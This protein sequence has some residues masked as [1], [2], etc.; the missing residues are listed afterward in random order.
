MI[1]V[2]M[3]LR[4]WALGTTP[5][6]LY[7]DEAFNGLDA[8]GVLEGERPIFFE[9][10]NGR[11]PLFIYLVALS[12]AALGRSPGAIRIVAALLGTLTIPA[13]YLMAKAMFD[14]RIGLLA[15]A[16]TGLTLW[17]V[18]LS[19]IGFRTVAMP[20]L[21]ALALW[22]LWL[23]L[24]SGNRRHFLAGGVAYG[25]T[26]Y[27]YLAARFTIL[28]LAAFGLYLVGNWRL[29]VGGWKM[30]VG[31]WKLE[32]GGW[33]RG[34]LAFVLAAL[35]VLVPLMTY[36]ATH[37]D[38]FLGRVGQVSIFS[39]AINDGDF[40]GTLLRHMGKT[41][42]MFTN[43]G[44]F[45][46]RHNVPL[47]PVFDPVLSVFFLL[48]L[49]LCF[50]RF[51]QRAEHALV[52]IWLAVMILPTILA[53]D[54]PHF[55]RSVGVLPVAFV[56]P[57]IGLDY[58]WRFLENRITFKVQS[59]K[60]KAQTVAVGAVAL[61][62]VFGLGD[63]TI[64][65]FGR[66]AGSQ[67]LSY[68]FEAAAVRLAT[69][70]NRFLST[71]WDGTGLGDRGNPPSPGRH[72]YIAD[73]LWRDWASVRFLVPP[74]PNLTI[75]A[76]SDK[77]PQISSDLGSS[78]GVLSSSKGRT[79]T[80]VML[81][82]WPYEDYGQYLSLLPVGSTIAAQ[83]GSLE[84]GDLEK[85]ARLLYITYTATPAT[86]PS[87]ELE[88]RFEKGL[89]LV[90][91]RLTAISP[92]EL[93]L[94]LL[95]RAEAEIEADYT[96]F[97]HLI[98]DGFDT[99]SA[100]LRQAQDTAQPKDA[101]LSQDD[102]PPAGGYYPTSLWRVGDIVSDE[103]T[104]ALPEPYDPGEHKLIVGFYQLETLYRLQVLD[105]TGKPVNDHLILGGT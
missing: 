71:G 21:V 35:V 78:S 58:L 36:V 85:E 62:L 59:S 53:E 87:G 95:W 34:A 16:V 102:S 12:V 63:T 98:R 3:A 67:D 17:H 77:L 25:L 68:N 42:L 47:R 82:L 61:A 38:A 52:L 5:P 43:R 31:R 45:I 72:L 104:L 66:H 80:E 100:T 91:H 32:D 83:E 6:G 79:E 40:W 9:A 29:E 99:P 93:R 4:F 96:V 105:E 22:Q 7:H 56:V 51:R 92:Q 2:A 30:E 101:I 37:W 8:L 20:L 84:R 81:I 103:H 41:L 46:P 90:G 65:Y 94:S 26:F 33:R 89:T 97:V 75:L 55:L 48:G 86:I 28:A 69:Q 64:D 74:S 19:R 10:N 88:A 54:A 14:R 13:A 39:P 11:E 18:N 60:F 50:I 73:R 24:K 76:E 1:A 57:A 44:D 27:T 70:A 15:A 49:I 23:G